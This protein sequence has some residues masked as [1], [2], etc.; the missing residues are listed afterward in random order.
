[1]TKPKPSEIKDIL[2]DPVEIVKLLDQYIV[3]QEDAKKILSVMLLNRGLRQL[4]KW[5]VINLTA[6]LEKSNVLLIGPTG[7]GK[8]AMLKAL[9]EIADVPVSIFDI[10]SVT[11]AGYI[12]NK[13]EDVILNHVVVCEQYVKE[14]Y[15][16]LIGDTEYSGLYTRADMTREYIESG[17][18]YIDEF[19]KSRMDKESNG[20]D[21]NGRAVQSELLKLIENG[22]VD[23]AQSRSNRKI[24]TNIQQ[25]KTDDIVYVCGGA[26]SGLDDIIS[27]R[28]SKT[29]GLGFTSDVHS[30]ETIKNNN[31]IMKHLTNDDLIEFGIM[32]ELLGR[33]P[34][35]TSLSPLSKEMMIRIITEPKDSV[36]SQYQA[37]FKAFNIDLSIEKQALDL[38]AEKA[39]ALKIGA[40]SLKTI[41]GQLLTDS[42]F[43]IF[44]HRGKKFVIDRELILSK[45][46]K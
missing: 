36:L 18:V 41:F 4:H 45:E 33:L 24:D 29:S 11:S 22:V 16:Q 8:T 40:R 28:L 19:D 15:N 5:D 13:V 10:T 38:L 21:V 7:T 1:M 17:I 39:L 6:K 26:F 14:N 20:R 46:I 25:I 42:L 35:K 37:T 30:I 12:G 23:L 3:G 31:E 2:T 32:P 9:S 34:L 44:S 27:R 43:N